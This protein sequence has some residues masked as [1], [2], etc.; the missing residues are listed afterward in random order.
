MKDI[1]IYLP[2]GPPQ[3]RPKCVVELANPHK[4]HSSN[5]A[6]HHSGSC[7]GAL[8]SMLDLVLLLDILK[9]DKVLHYNYARPL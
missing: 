1:C 5:A 4:L 8:E 3:P 2:E 9:L 7:G 6:T